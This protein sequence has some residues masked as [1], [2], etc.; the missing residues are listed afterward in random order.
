MSRN[1]TKNT[2]WKG[3]RTKRP[4]RNPRE[5]TSP[6]SVPASRPI[7]QPWLGPSYLDP[8]NIVWCPH[9]HGVTTP[10][11][12]LQYDAAERQAMLD[13]YRR[14]I[15]EGF[16]RPRK[17]KHDGQPRLSRISQRLARVLHQ[18]GKGPR[19]LKIV[20]CGESRLLILR[21]IRRRPTD[22]NINDLRQS[23]PSR[24]SH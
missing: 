10:E 19:N 4:T 17:L 21:E 15:L 20:K 6:A 11:D 13:W 12:R 14:N 5:V 9:W 16:K 23:S 18:V 24:V 8:E 7:Y 3:K 1:G 2:K 22:I